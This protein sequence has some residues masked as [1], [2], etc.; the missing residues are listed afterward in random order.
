MVPGMGSERPV[1]LY[2]LR[3]VSDV[4][5]LPLERLIPESR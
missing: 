5:Q 2:K 3:I 4:L 1:P